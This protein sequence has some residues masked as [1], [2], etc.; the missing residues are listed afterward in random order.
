[1]NEREHERGNQSTSVLIRLSWGTNTHTPYDFRLTRGY[2]LS[3][4]QPT[5]SREVCSSRVPQPSRFP[6]SSAS[7]LSRTHELPNLTIATRPDIAYT[8]GLPCRF[9]DNPVMEH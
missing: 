5:F 4:I 7:P 9:V 2:R 1:M 3:A 8:A 6:S